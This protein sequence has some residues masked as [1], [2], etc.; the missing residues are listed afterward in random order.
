MAGSGRCRR[1]VGPG[2]LPFWQCRH[3]PLPPV[4]P[5]RLLS[6]LE[7]LAQAVVGAG[8]ERGDLPLHHLPLL[9]HP[10]P[11]ACTGGQRGV[12]GASLVGAQPRP[13]SSIPLKPTHRSGVP[14]PQADTR[15]LHPCR[16]KGGHTHLP[17]ANSACRSAWN[18]S[19]LGGASRMSADS[20]RHSSCGGRGSGGSTGSRAGRWWV[21]DAAGHGTRCQDA[22][23]VPDAVLSPP[24]SAQ[25]N[26]S[27]PAAAH[28]LGHL[29]LD[30]SAQLSHAAVDGRKQLPAWQ[31]R[32]RQLLQ[33]ARGHQAAAPLVRVRRQRER[34]HEQDRA[35]HASSPRPRVGRALQRGPEGAHLL[36][37][38]QLDNATLFSGGPLLPWQQRRQAGIQAR[39]LQLCSRAG[40]P[41]SAGKQSWQA[42]QLHQLGPRT[43]VAPPPCRPA[44][45]CL[46]AG[47]WLSA[48]RTASSAAP[49]R[50]APPP[51]R[52]AQSA[53]WPGPA[54]RRRASGPGARPAAAAPG[55]APVEAWGRFG[56]YHLLPLYLQGL[57]RCF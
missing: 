48:A 55:S 46:P 7:P 34:P 22:S 35:G 16:R 42:L 20:S 29:A 50:P 38:L 1:E 30:C 14:W 57:R 10:L 53:G 47:R 23:R 33:Q 19:A 8:L 37:D 15:A 54:T 51:V 56:V 18:C 49:P 36:L 2:G 9:L 45:R 4:P 12:L 11:D 17:A 41:L 32:S 5:R 52:P 43:Q 25:G 13:C 26:A 40:G 21:P 39:Q 28:R 31:G 6:L 27:S 3:G 24:R 44:G